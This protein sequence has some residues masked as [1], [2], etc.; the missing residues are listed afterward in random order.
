MTTPLHCPR[1]NRLH[2]AE[3]IWS[4]VASLR[5]SVMTDARREANKARAKKRWAKYRREK[6]LAKPAPVA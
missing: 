6:K 2:S 4:A 5:G 1:C 3:E